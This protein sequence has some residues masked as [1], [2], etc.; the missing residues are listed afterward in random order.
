MVEDYA[1]CRRPWGFDPGEIAAP[2]ILSHG[3]RDRLVPFAH[4]LWLASAIRD[5]S[6]HSVPGAGH[7]F[8]SRHLREIVGPLAGRAGSQER[9]TPLRLAA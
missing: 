2:V 1:V 4:A 7:F 9:P 6:I 8:L 3:R 5:C